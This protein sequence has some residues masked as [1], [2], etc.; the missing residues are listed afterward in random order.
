MMLFFLLPEDDA[1]TMGHSAMHDAA[2]FL[3]CLDV[4]PLMLTMVVVILMVGSIMMI[5][6]M[7]ILMGHNTVQDGSAHSFFP[8]FRSL[9]LALKSLFAVRH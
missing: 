7:P 2:S 1:M 3:Q 6:T 9:P 8:S 5:M 4:F